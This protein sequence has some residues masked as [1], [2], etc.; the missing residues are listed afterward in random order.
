VEQQRQ[1]RFPVPRYAAVLAWLA[2]GGVIGGLIGVVSGWKLHEGQMLSDN[3]ARAAPAFARQAAVA[4]VV[5]SPE[6]RHPVEVGADQEAHLVA[7]LSKR[8]GTPLRVPHLGEQGFSLV[9]GRLLP[10]QP[11][12]RLPVAQFMYQ[13]SKGFRLTL[14]VRADAASSRETAFR[15]AQEKNVRVFYWVDQKLGYALSGEIE[16]AELLRVANAVYKQL[17]P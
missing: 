12:D 13:D 6:V 8:L 2:V 17:N 3:N 14:Y 5:F 16:K 10:G 1:P 15:F 4:H 7:W 9:G 11:D